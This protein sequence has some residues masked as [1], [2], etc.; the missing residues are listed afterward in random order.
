[1]KGGASVWWPTPVGAERW[2]TE[3][4]RTAARRYHRPVERA[5]VVRLAAHAIGLLSVVAL[6]RTVSLG[7]VETIIAVELAIAVPR[8]VVDAWHEFVHEPR[9]GAE[10]VRRWAFGVTVVGRM[11]FETLGLALVS[12]WLGSIGGGLLSVAVVG[13]VAFAIPIASALFGPRV[14]L[15]M[16]RASDVQLD[17]PGQAIAARRA[18]DFALARPRLVALDSAAFDGVNAFATGTGRH[19]TVAVSDR[20]LAAPPD[21]FSH[22]I[23]HEFAHIRRRH[24]GWSA[25]ASGS[26]AGIVVAASVAATV[27]LAGDGQRLPLLVLLVGLFGLPLRLGLAWLSRFNERQADRDA[28]GAA[29]ISPHLLKQ[30]HL[31]DR[32]AIEPSLVGRFF[33]AHPPPAERLDHA[34]RVHGAAGLPSDV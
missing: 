14:V 6:S 1:M 4:E 16:H 30:L 28:A 32:A 29:P 18:D 7:T 3:S 33:G 5:A 20:L 22:V 34:A 15:A 8:V 31:S 17:H 25:L 21:L 11:A 27:D 24:L 9:F 12:P 23:G 10:P 2:F 13:G 19:V 26:A